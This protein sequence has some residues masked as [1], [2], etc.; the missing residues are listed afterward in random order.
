LKLSLRKKAGPSIDFL[1][2]FRLGAKPNVCYTPLARPGSAC[3]RGFM[4]LIRSG[5]ASD[6]F[7]KF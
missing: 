7:S 5:S 3:W 1:M 6:W 4:A 2:N